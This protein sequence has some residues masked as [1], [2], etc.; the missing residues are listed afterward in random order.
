MNLRSVDL[1]LL[2]VLDAILAEAHVS[3]AA[4]RLGLSQPAASAALDRCRHLFSDPLLRRQ[5]HGMQLTPR[6]VQLQPQI[7]QLLQQLQHIL[8]AEQ[9]DVASLQQDIRLICAEL[10][11]QQLLLPLYQLLN[12]HAPGVRLILLPWHGADQAREALLR[13][14]AD[15]ALSVFAELSPAFYSQQILQEHYRLLLR[16]DHPLCTDYQLQHWLQYP[17]ILV[18][19]QGQSFSALDQQLLAL[20]HHRKVALVVPGFLSVPELVANSDLLAF[21]PSRCI[22]PQDRRFSSLPPLLPMAG[23]NLYLACHQRQAADPALQLVF[24]LLKQLFP[25]TRE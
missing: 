6:A 17:H 14:E 24:R 7:R 12:Q 3:R 11:P 20:G 13:G 22:P 1:N 10:P 25:A 16:H 21:L 23:F 18:S 2:V 9:N 8:A 15:L 5:Q 4:Q 19:G